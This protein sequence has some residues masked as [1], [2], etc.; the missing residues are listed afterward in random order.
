MGPEAHRHLLKNLAG[1]FKGEGIQDR[2][3][4]IILTG[5]MKG[6][7]KRSAEQTKKDFFQIYSS[8]KIKGLFRDQLRSKYRPF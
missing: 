1:A 6:V 7:F 3:K 5:N 8:D 2:F 4:R